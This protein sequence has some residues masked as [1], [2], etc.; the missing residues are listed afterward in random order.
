MHTSSREG[1]LSSCVHKGLEASNESRAPLNLEG[2]EFTMLLQCLTS[3]CNFS[4]LI[5]EILLPKGMTSACAEQ[6]NILVEIPAIDLRERSACVVTQC[7]HRHS[8]KEIQIADRHHAQAA[9]HPFQ[10]KT[11]A[12]LLTRRMSSPLRQ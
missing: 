11:A 2:M 12:F 1:H 7:L 4:V 8:N 9:A 6:K 10:Y 3:P 5:N